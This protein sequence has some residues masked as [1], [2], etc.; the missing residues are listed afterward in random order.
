MDFPEKKQVNLYMQD[1]GKL[2]KR[3]LGSRREE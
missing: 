1:I 3:I 2:K